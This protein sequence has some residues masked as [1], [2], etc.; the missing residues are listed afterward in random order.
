MITLTR[1]NGE[2][3][4]V[5][6]DLIEFIDITP[7]TIISMTTG[8]KFLV[9]ESL[10]TVKS[11]IITYKQEIYNIPFIKGNAINNNENQED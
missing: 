1:L 9:T 11:K 7:D 4:M 3:F 10:E 6:D 8:K 2:E 5:N